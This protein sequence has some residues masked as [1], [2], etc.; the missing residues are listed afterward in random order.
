LEKKSAQ[1]YA[2]TDACCCICGLVPVRKKIV[3]SFSCQIQ[4][5]DTYFYSKVSKQFELTCI[6][7]NLCQA[8]PNYTKNK[9]KSL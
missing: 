5:V 4:R 3:Y 8:S 7:S 6:T 9:I 2:G 1:S